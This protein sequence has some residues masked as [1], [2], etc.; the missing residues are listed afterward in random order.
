MVGGAKLKAQLA[1]GA[2]AMARGCLKIK[3]GI[4]GDALLQRPRSS[5]PGIAVRRTASLTLAYDPVIHASN[6]EIDVDGRVK[7]GHD[8]LQARCA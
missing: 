3:S 5:S 1:H 8:E 7:P 4:R 6:V 2:G